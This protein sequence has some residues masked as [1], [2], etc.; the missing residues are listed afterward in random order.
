M[1]GHT[2]TDFK[3]LRK[4]IGEITKDQPAKSRYQQQAEKMN[5][6]EAAVPF[7]KQKGMKSRFASTAKIAGEKDIK[8]AY[9]KI[10]KSAQGPAK[11]QK[12]MMTKELE[13]M[14]FNSYDK[15]A[16]DKFF[17]GLT[18]NGLL[19]LQEQS[20]EE[21]SLDN[22]MLRKDFPNVW[23]TKDN[24]LYRVLNVLINMHGH[25]TNLSSYKK[26]K[27]SFL[28]SLKKIADSPAA[29][30]R[31]QFG[32]KDMNYINSPSKRDKFWSATFQTPESVDEGNLLEGTWAVPDTRAKIMKLNSLLQKPFPINNEKDEDRAYRLFSPLV[33]DDTVADSWY[34][35][36]KPNSAGDAR[37]P[38]VKFLKDWGGFRLKGK[39][40]THAP[41][42]YIKAESVEEKKL[43]ELGMKKRPKGNMKKPRGKSVPIETF[44][45]KSPFKL[46][47]EQYPRAIAID[48]E[49]YGVRHATA[50]DIVIA[51][52]TFGM[53]TD[54]ELQIEQIQKALGKLGF[55]SYKKQE[56]E[57]VFHERETQRIILALESVTEEQEILEYT[58]EQ[59]Q[60]RYD[61]KQEIKFLK[62]DGMK[63]AGPVL[64]LSGNTYN[65]KDKHTGKS[66]TYKY[67][68]E[69]EVKTFREVM[70]EGFSSSLVKKAI[71]IANSKEFKGG[72]YSGAQRA[73]EKLKKGLSDDPKV[74]DAL[75]KANESVKEG[76]M[77]DIMIDFEQGDDDKTIAKRYKLSPS[78]VKGLRKDWKQWNSVQKEE[79]NMK[80]WTQP[81]QGTFKEYI[82]SDGKHKKVKEGDKRRK[83]NKKLESNKLDN[84]LPE[85][86]KEAY[87]KFFNKAMKK[88][89]ISSPDELEGD[90]KKEFFDYVDKNWKADHEEKD[91]HK[92]YK[93]DGRRTNFREKMRKLGYV[94]GQ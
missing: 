61:S 78:V 14:G 71:A 62:P 66:F 9:M 73:I 82:K 53:I 15:K 26:D 89:G 36:T 40:I 75:K 17:E 92:S 20:L 31:A 69:T 70:S 5:S 42:E 67:I 51:C 54:K 2:V 85:G 25:N 49:G 22:N 65:V 91:I 59:I 63:A 38:I 29:Q 12:A 90:K 50:N 87:Q 6:K 47:T 34:G 58:R 64:K 56:L 55:I 23:A 37:E 77:K 81:G 83:E 80:S 19:Q 52:E 24:K 46:K 45:S 32:F 18:I 41:A 27:K 33:G 13:K 43:K 60:E 86:D 11:K 68:E 57:D 8:K 88:F 48:G 94:K 72:N 7:I 16:M 84:W 10:G 28:D 3:D 93:V 79:E 39:R 76:K 1:S 21:I 4:L 35:M 30:K 74:A 44:K